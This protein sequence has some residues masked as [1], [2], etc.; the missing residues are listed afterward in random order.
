MSDDNFSIRSIFPLFLTAL[1]DFIGFGIIIPIGPYYVEAL[2]GTSLDF[3]ILIVTYSIAQ[4][5][6]SP[7]LGGLSD[8]YGRKRVLSIGLSGEILG[9]LLFA[10]SPN[11]SLLFV[12]RAII[13]VTSANLPV[14]YSFVSDKT[15]SRNRTKAIGFIGAAIGIGFVIGPAIGGLLSLV[16]FRVAILGA[17]LLA[18]LNLALVQRL[19]EEVKRVK[20]RK[21]SRIGSFKSFPL[22]FLS[23]LTVGMGFTGLQTTLAYYGQALYSWTALVVGI[24]LAIVGIQQAIF[25]VILIPRL[26]SRI[27]PIKTVIVGILF[28]TTSFVI[29]SFKNPQYVIFV[30][31]SLFS[32][33]YSLFQTPIISLIS[34]DSSQ[35]SRGMNLGIAQSAQSIA[36]IF[37]PLI[38]GYLFYSV[39][40][41]AQY[42]ISAFLGVISLVFIILHL[43]REGRRTSTK[44][45]DNEL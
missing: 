29:L 11:L 31:L 39:S 6:A 2:G 19:K 43:V 12:S 1:I 28:F 15:D 26:E 18:T 33:G 37:G 45:I 14:L 22:I 8:K 30:A 25:Q 41:F 20:G 23:I 9:Y 24:I 32:L 38:A 42:E 5:I 34:R 13:G 44:K 7:Y 4:F 16:G 17:A 27:G 21:Y 36:N 35:G 3:S 40:R 10:L